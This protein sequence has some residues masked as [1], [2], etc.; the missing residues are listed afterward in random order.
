MSHSVE[1]IGSGPSAYVL[2]TLSGPLRV[3]IT[4]DL[5]ARTVEAGRSA[6]LTRAI[7]DLR[8][9]RMED[10]FLDVHS[11]MEGLQAL[12]VAYSDQV[13]I[14]YQND[15]ERHLHAENVAFNRGFSQMRYF[16]DMELAVKW[17]TGT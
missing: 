8:E 11:F 1:V 12:G 13:A 7:F 15:S 17:I 9:T 16:T 6:G 10:S 5:V 3:D 14:V 4:S 2:A